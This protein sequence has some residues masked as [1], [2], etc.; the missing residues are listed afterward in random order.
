MLN[1]FVGSTSNMPNSQFLTNASINWSGSILTLMCDFY[2]LQ[3][4]S[5]VMVGREFSN[6]TLLFWEINS[7]YVSINIDH[8]GNYT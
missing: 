4:V 3:N 7:N 8:D 5:C 2:N 6:K 1:L